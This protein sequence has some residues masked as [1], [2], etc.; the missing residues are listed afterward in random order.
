MIVFALMFIKK[1]MKSINKKND[2]NKYI[3]GTA[4]K[5][6]LREIAKSHQVIIY[7]K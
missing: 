6:A 2:K 7:C 4:R 1:K 3:C 5:V